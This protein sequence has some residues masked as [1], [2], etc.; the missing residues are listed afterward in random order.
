M[1]Q[2]YFIWLAI[3]LGIGCLIWGFKWIHEVSSSKGWVQRLGSVL[4]VFLGAACLWAAA[5]S[6]SP[7]AV[8]QETEIVRAGPDWV[9]ARI[10]YDEARKC[11]VNEVRGVFYNDGK[12]VQSDSLFLPILPISE[13][14]S[15]GYVVSR[16]RKDS[17]A[18]QF[19]VVITATCTFGFVMKSE[20]P[21]VQL[22][23]SLM[24]YD[25]I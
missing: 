21:I 8:N 2:D 24:S 11:K 23:I 20:F 18:D 5:A 10:E 16:L 14:R 3:L 17:L 25:P 15:Y 12:E 13:K 7:I 4:T 6:V 19:K 9:I 1:S 22:P